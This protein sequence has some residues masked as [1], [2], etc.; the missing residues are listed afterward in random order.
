MHF[1]PAKADVVATVTAAAATTDVAERAAGV[2]AKEA[3]ASAVG[4]AAGLLN[5]IGTKFRCN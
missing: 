1:L 3:T 5:L 4:I 2:A